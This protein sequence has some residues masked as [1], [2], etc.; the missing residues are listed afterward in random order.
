MNDVLSALE[1]DQLDGSQFEDDEIEV[2]VLL[3]DEGQS[4]IT[5]ENSD[6]FDEEATGAFVHWPCRILNAKVETPS[7]ACTSALAS[8]AQKQPAK[9]KKRAPRNWGRKI[10]PSKQLSEPASDY[11]PSIVGYLNATIYT[12]LDAFLSLFSKDLV[13]EITQQTIIYAQ[14]RRKI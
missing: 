2:A 5:D 3:P 12:P 13:N 6:M 11:G 9:K 14:Q 10:L 8:E 4:G 7:L 1:E